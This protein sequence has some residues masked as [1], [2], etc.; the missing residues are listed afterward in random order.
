MKHSDALPLGRDPLTGGVHE[1]RIRYE[2]QLRVPRLHRA[3]CFSFVDEMPRNAHQHGGEPTWVAAQ[4]DDDAV[5]VAVR[6]HGLLE[7]AIDGGHPDEPAGDA[8]RE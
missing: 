1:A 8:G 5:C 2:P 7:L 3:E 4:I 6:A